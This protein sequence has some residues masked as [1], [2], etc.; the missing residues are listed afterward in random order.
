MKIE[1]P[2]ISAGVHLVFLTGEGK[3]DEP[4]HMKGKS[5]CLP[6][7]HSVESEDRL[8]HDQSDQQNHQEGISASDIYSGMPIDGGEIVKLGS[9]KL[10]KEAGNDLVDGE[11]TD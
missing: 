1:L 8:I 9:E 3:I 10:F 11:K 5:G 7:S 6:H 2:R 4:H